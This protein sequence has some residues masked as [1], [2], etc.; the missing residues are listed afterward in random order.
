MARWM[1]ALAVSNE[2]GRGVCAISSAGSPATFQI[3][4][5]LDECCSLFEETMSAFSG[6]EP[7]WTNS[8]IHRPLDAQAFL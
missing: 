4:M 5:P 3:G 7:R 6:M 1:R 2:M 8:R